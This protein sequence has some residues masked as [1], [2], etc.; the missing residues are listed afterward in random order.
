MKKDSDRAS[1]TCCTLRPITAC[2]PC[3][4]SLTTPFAP[5]CLFNLNHQCPL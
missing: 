5:I 3:F 1:A 4:P 2:T